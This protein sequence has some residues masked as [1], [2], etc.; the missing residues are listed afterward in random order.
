V[1]T[2]DFANGLSLSGFRVPSLKT[3]RAETEVELRDGQSFA[4]A[5]LLDN[6]SF[7]SRQSIPFLSSIPI[8]G[9]LFSSKS[10]TATRT[11]LL[12]LITPHLVRPLDPAEVPP[13]PIDQRPFIRPQPGI[14][15]LL[16]GGGGLVDAPSPD[17]VSKESRP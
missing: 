4:I 2:L 3:R 9:H 15:G 11:E 14:G 17:A 13:L 7:E 8:V 16:Q 6:Q 10:D 5:G 12:V 1:S